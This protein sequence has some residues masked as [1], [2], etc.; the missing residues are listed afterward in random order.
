MPNAESPSCDL[1]NP[2]SGEEP[3]KPKRALAVQIL[4]SAWAVF[5]LLAMLITPNRNT[6]L[7]QL[8]SGL[9]EP[10]ANFLELSSNWNFFAPQPGPPLRLEFEAVGADGE[11]QHHGFWPELSSPW[12]QT[13][14]SHFVM[15]DMNGG[16]RLVGR[17]L[18]HQ[19]PSA[20]SVRVWRNIY[21]IPSLD[22]VVAGKRSI[23]DSSR[24]TRQ[25]IGDFVCPVNSGA[26]TQAQWSEETSK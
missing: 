11:Q 7:G 21:T 6:Y 25:F 1:E 18:C 15:K 2:A 23:D 9:M 20:Q 13:T 16:E 3:L 4:L 5:H 12:R 24:V 10:Y 14:L 19:N 17:F 8:F 22:E 26:W